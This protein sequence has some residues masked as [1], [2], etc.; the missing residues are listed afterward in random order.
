MEKLDSEQESFNEAIGLANKS[1]ERKKELEG[2]K[3]DWLA[4]MRLEGG[5]MAEET[6]DM[7]R[8]AVPEAEFTVVFRL[9]AKSGET[10]AEYPENE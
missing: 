3:A 6:A 5:R 7:I 8:E 9:C 10:I 4:A 1:N 2:L